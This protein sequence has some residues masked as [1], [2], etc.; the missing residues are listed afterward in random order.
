M[1]Q[2]VRFYSWKCLI[3]VVS[4][5]SY[6][7][8]KSLLFVFPITCSIASNV[9]GNRQFSHRAYIIC[10]RV[11]PINTTV[12]PQSQRKR[13]KTPITAANGNDINA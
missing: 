6:G 9:V 10:T 7:K 3:L 11:F 5:S 1:L 4:Y 8:Y 12:V 2:W 13:N